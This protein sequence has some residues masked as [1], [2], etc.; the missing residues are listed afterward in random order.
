[1]RVHLHLQ[2]APSQSFKSFFIVFF[3]FKQRLLTLVRNRCAGRQN[4]EQQH[5]KNKIS[6]N[7]TKSKKAKIHIH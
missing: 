3:A 1:M 2:N 6:S 7:G 5:K 4:A